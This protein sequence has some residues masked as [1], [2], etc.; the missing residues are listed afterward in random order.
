MGWLVHPRPCPCGS[1]RVA[2]DCCGRFTRLSEADVA[3]AHLHRLA[4]PARDLV[5]PFSPGGFDGL[6]RE[7][8]GLPGRQPKVAAALSGRAGD[9][10]ARL[11][12]AAASRDE[13]SG[14][15][16]IRAVVG[17]AQLPLARVALAKAIIALREDRTV[18]EHLAAA[19]ILD[20]DG[21]KSELLAAAL[22]HAV[23]EARAQCETGRRQ[24][25]RG[26]QARTA[27]TV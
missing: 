10:V 22:R 18:D 14:R 8:A 27:A 1:G 12:N 11:V 26:R 25:G 16:L 20:L 21:P 7:L 3:R 4:R 9:E 6:R 2:R 24:R 15:S 17:Q 23:V 13:E 19:A 5:A